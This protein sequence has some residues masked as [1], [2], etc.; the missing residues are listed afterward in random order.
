MLSFICYCTQV[1]CTKQKH[2]LFL[3]YY[4]QFAT[5]LP[6]ILLE[7]EEKKEKEGRARDL[8]S[9]KYLKPSVKANVG[10]YI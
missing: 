4:L 5:Y 6:L 9:L 8:A 2:I 3:I 1:H 10:L 7:R